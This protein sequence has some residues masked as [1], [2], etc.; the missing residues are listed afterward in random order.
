MEVGLRE[1]I[2]ELA[3]ERRDEAFDEVLAAADVR[4]E[5]ETSP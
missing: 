2:S 3:G 5:A 1:L 4:S